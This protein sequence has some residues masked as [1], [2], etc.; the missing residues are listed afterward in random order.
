MKRT[1]G[2]HA[3]AFERLATGCRFGGANCNRRFV[4][5]GTV[6]TVHPRQPQFIA[7]ARRSRRISAACNA[8]RH[9]ARY[10]ALSA[11]RGTSVRRHGRRES[12]NPPRCR[13]GL[14]HRR[15]DAIRMKC[16][17]S[18][19]RRPQPELQLTR[20]NIMKK[21]LAHR[22]FAAAAA[23]AVTFA[24]VAGVVAIADHEKEQAVFLAAQ[25]SPPTL[26]QGEVAARR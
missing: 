9:F 18:D 8:V 10:D 25:I 14:V 22:T 21:S 5:F 3:A 15:P 26:A 23:A 12:V 16:E 13:H 19:S 17:A 11:A 4:A 24:V 1:V 7:P 6:L 20:E 2:S